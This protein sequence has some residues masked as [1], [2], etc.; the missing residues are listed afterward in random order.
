MEKG[1]F[2]DKKVI[3]DEYE[4]KKSDI[5]AEQAKIIKLLQQNEKMQ[6]E[7]IPKKS[8]GVFKPT[9]TSWA[10]V[11]EADKKGVNDAIAA[12]NEVRIAK[13]KSLQETF[14]KQYNDYSL[15]K[16]EIDRK[17]EADRK[18][19][20]DIRSQYKEGTPEYD[21]FTL[22][23]AQ[24]EKKKVLEQA[25][26]SFSQLKE[27]PIYSLASEDATR[28][29]IEGLQRL[30]AILQKYKQAAID[31]YDP[32]SIRTWSQ[33]IDSA[34]ANLAKRDPINTLKKS[35]EDLVKANS[36]VTESTKALT[37]A[38]KEYNEA[39]EEAA[40][41]EEKKKYLKKRIES[42]SSDS[43]DFYSTPQSQEQPEVQIPLEAPKSDTWSASSATKEQKLVNVRKQLADVTSKSATA[44]TKLDIVTGKQIGRAHV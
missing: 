10:N 13:E 2:H 39:A 5:E 35:R 25:K 40:R 16:L 44:N 24:N 21:T 12:A 18:A 26:L 38:Q 37:E 27:S 41:I 15:Q 22:R 17:Y 4:K 9:V 42:I 1:Y 6:W 20:I 36:E 3:E 14:L 8:R 19:L 23:L 11:P 32:E 43:S 34:M 29:S 28:V 7:N 31:A 33:E 30:V